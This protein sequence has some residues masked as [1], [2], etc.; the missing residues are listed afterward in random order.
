MYIF[1]TGTFGHITF[2]GA[3]L[4]VKGCVTGALRLQNMDKIRNDGGSKYI[5]LMLLAL[6]LP[7]ILIYTVDH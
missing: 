4:P 7:I 2:T 3:S 1:I 6:P 5:I